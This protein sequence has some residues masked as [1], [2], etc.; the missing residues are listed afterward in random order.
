M[1]ALY[2]DKGRTLCSLLDL[3][4]T[5]LNSLIL[6]HYSVTAFLPFTPT[7][8]VISPDLQLDTRFHTSSIYSNCKV[9]VDLS[10]SA[11]SDNQVPY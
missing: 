6:R 5:C 4:T 1:Y 9:R 2:E 10:V 11:G 7:L 3:A 8:E